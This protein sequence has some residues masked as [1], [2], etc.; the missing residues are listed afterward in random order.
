GNRD[1]TS[2]INSALQAAARVASADRPQVVLLRAGVY[3]ISDTIMVDHSYVVLRGEGKGRTILRMTTPGK[4]VV[5]VGRLRAYTGVMDGVGDV[6]GGAPRL[7]VTEARDIQA[8]DVLQ[9]DQVEDGDARGTRGWVWRYDNEWLMRGP[10]GHEDA[11][12]PDSPSGYRPIG[13]Q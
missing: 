2:A 10:R 7:T 1:A 4:G 9:I 5:A 13:Q 3:T 8:G 11:T 6:A 12:G